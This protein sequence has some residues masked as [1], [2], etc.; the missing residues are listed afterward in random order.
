MGQKGDRAAKEP[1]AIRMYAGG[2]SIEAIAPELDV[3]PTSLR[4]WKSQS[5]APNADID[6]WDR[7][8]QQRRGISQRLSDIYEAQI[9]YLEELLP[10]QRTAPMIDALSKLG[11]LLEQKERAEAGG[12][13]IDRPAFF[14]ETVQ[15]IAEYLKEKDPEALK[16]LA[17]NVDAII[18]AFKRKHEA[19]A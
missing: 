17:R 4:L 8:R 10:N 3:S 5:R 11:A 2:K 14:L 9:K 7:A 13:K 15:F 16:A 18:E 19:A 6:E 1:L 12:P